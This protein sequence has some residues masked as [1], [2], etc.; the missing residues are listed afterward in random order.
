MIFGDAVIDNGAAVREN[1]HY[2]YKQVRGYALCVL[3]SLAGV[4]VI[5]SHDCLHPC[6]P[7]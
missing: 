4:F 1:V 3:D 6:D 7:M 5:K 2:M